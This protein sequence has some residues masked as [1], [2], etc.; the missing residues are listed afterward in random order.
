MKTTTMTKTW[1]E[2]DVVKFKWEMAYRI[3]LKSIDARK[4]T[5]FA[6]IDFIHDSL[7]DMDV[8]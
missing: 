6:F 2:E 3:R 7:S 4:R 8:A 1:H 5:L